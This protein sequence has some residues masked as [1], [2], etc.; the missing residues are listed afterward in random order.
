LPELRAWITTRL[1]DYKAPDHLVL[2]DEIPLTAMSKT[3]RVRLR[4]LVD[5]HPP[6]RRNT[7]KGPRA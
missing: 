6:T 7:E 3:D 1:A 2:V 5:A 4:E